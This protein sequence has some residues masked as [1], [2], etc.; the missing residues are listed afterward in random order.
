MDRDVIQLAVQDHPEARK[1]SLSTDIREKGNG[2]IWCSR[3]AGCYFADK[4]LIFP[5][6]RPIGNISNGNNYLCTQR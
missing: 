2:E 1:L 6:F 3:C 5:R 4:G